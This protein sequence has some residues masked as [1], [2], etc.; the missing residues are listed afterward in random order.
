M[1]L[2]FKKVSITNDGRCFV[3]KYKKDEY[4]RSYYY[5]D[6]ES[7]LY[8]LLNKYLLK[9]EAKEVN[10]ILKEIKNLKSE[11]KKLNKDK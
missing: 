2:N 11:I 9:S 3:L 8:N 1:E 7:L 5:A 4:N 10:D 6:F